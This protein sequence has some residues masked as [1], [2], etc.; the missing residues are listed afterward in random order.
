MGYQWILTAIGGLGLFLLGMI[1]L[2]DGLRALAGEKLTRILSRFTSS[3]TTG[4]LTGAMVTATLQSSSATTVAAVGFVAAGLLTFTQALGIIF[5]ANLG[6]TITGW[7]VALIGFKLKLGTLSL[8][9]VFTGVILR[10]FAKGRVASLGLSLAGFGLVFVGIDMLQEG[11]SAFEGRVTPDDFPDDDFTGR[12][13]LLTIGLLITLITQSSSAGVA[14]ALTALF[15]GAISFPQAAV[16]VI[17]MDIGTTV[18]AVI[19][20]VGGA[21][22]TRRTGISHMIYNIMTALLALLILTPY[23]TLLDRLIPGVFN[24]NPEFALVGFHSL[25]NGLGIILILPFAGQ[26]ARLIETIVKEK[27][28]PLSSHLDRML[29][30]EPPTA[31]SAVKRTLE[32]MLVEL[33][34]CLEKQ[35]LTADACPHTE[36]GRLDAAIRKTRAF[37]DDIHLVDQSGFHWKQLMASLH[38][39][40]HL[41]RLLRRMSQVEC[42]ECAAD[43]D[44]LELHFS[45]LQKLVAEL[46]HDGSDEVILRDSSELSHAIATAREGLREKIISRVGD[47]SVT[48]NEGHSL[49]RTLRW[50]DRVAHHLWRISLHLQEIE[51]ADRTLISSK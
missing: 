46:A 32:D 22:A 18:T 35:L 29:L 11:M 1:I 28:D 40:D 49:L 31:L 44:L 42:I 5:G 3:P 36:T 20:S 41:Q 24:T 19:A 43:S 7:L 9:F 51:E 2:T 21:V 50:L 12:L 48:A 26:F 23:T 33:T 27:E 4:A 13:Q 34:K 6:T 17:G 45:Q 10:L 8:I 38:A 25:F 47:D 37:I 16:M 30:Q 14:T 15:A 39:L